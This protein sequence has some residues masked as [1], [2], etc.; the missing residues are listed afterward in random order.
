[1]NEAYPLKTSPFGLFLLQVCESTQ[2]QFERKFIYQMGISGKRE[3]FVFFKKKN[4]KIQKKNQ[5]RGW[6]RK[7]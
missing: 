5:K 1:M 2:D 3:V 7:A 4:L 6:I